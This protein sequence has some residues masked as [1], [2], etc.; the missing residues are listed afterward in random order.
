M[1]VWILAEAVHVPA[2]CDR[3]KQAL[4]SYCMDHPL[5][6]LHSPLRYK[7]AYIQ[8]TFN[9]GICRLVLRSQPVSVT[10]HIRYRDC[11]ECSNEIGGDGDIPHDGVGPARRIQVPQGAG[12][13][14]HRVM[15]EAVENH[16]PEVIVI[17]EIGTEAEALAARTVAQRGVRLIATAHGATRA[18]RLRV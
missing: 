14:Q 15:V 10:A 6:A 8:A 13:A 12:R 3:Q 2:A 18:L 1:H 5:Q 11:I 16:M 9:I 17:D 7:L 4:R